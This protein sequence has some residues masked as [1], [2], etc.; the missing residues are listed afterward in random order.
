MS[1]WQ[2]ALEFIMVFIGG[3]SVGYLWEYRESAFWRI[4][5]IKMEH[6]LARLENREPR[7]I[8]EVNK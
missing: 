4:Q 3:V 7:E 6:D 5:W 8:S 2:I 1:E